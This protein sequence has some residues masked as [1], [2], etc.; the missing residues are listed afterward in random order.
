M[1]NI[2]IQQ[3]DLER[4]L[5]HF[6]YYF[7]VKG[8]KNN[9]A[10]LINRIDTDWF[11]SKEIRDVIGYAK[12]SVEFGTPFDLATLAQTKPQTT[13]E[14]EFITNSRPTSSVDLYIKELH[15][16]YMKRNV[17]EEIGAIKTKIEKG[18]NFSV[19]TELLDVYKKI[20]AYT[21]NQEIPYTNKSIFK[22]LQDD[23]KEFLEGKLVVKTNLG[24]FDT[25]FGAYKRGEM[26]IIAAR[27]SMGKTSLMLTNALKM[28]DKT[29]EK[30]IS[31]DVYEGIEPVVVFSGEVPAKDM[32]KKMISIYSQIESEKDKSVGIIPSS[33]LMDFVDNKNTKTIVVDGEEKKTQLTFMDYQEDIKYMDKLIINK[34]AKTLIIIDTIGK[35]IDFVRE[36][37]MAIKQKHGKIKAVFLDY[38]QILKL[39]GKKNRNEE[40]ANVSLEIKTLAREIDA[41]FVVLAQLNRELEKREDK[42]PIPSDL[43]DSGSIEQDADKIIFLY[44]DDVY[45]KDKKSMQDEISPTEI[46]MAKNR[47]GATG[48]ISLLFHKETTAFATPP[49]GYGQKNNNENA[50]F[51]KEAAKNS[52]KTNINIPEAENNN[53]SKNNVIIA[54]L[55]NEKKDMPA[56]NS[57]NP[58]VNQNV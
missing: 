19:E 8:Q 22:E 41:P 25:K 11:T 57:D 46:I 2:K 43:K 29:P 13:R 37:L 26:I 42:R 44:R 4:S 20:S 7:S 27:P 45:N 32:R 49:S 31:D 54:D 24:S 40:V 33:I 12:K 48:T 38:L 58:E 3:I 18:E 15:K 9:L 1:N 53:E 6:I 50:Y 36:E 56:I 5:C 34:F 28:A 51:N 55:N 16:N 35:S 17:S 52:C 30:H 47:N 14:I 10:K 39:P 21:L 23:H